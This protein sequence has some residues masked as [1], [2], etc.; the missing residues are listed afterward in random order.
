M[1]DD[2][3]KDINE[4]RPSETHCLDLIR[5]MIKNSSTELKEC[6]FLYDGLYAEIDHP[7]GKTYTV[8]I[9]VK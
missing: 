9:K 7:D 5:N 4:P 3:L 6:Y 2:T 8:N 1:K